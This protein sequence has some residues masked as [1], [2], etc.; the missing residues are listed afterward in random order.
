M[1][2]YEYTALDIKG[3][4]VTGI[5]DA[6]SSSAARQK[7]RTTGMYPVSISESRKSAKKESRSF[8]SLASFSRISPAEISLTTRQMA[9][10]VGSGFPL[11]SAIDA[12]V[13]QTKSKGFKKIMAQ[14]K[15]SIVEG[16]SFSASLA[17]Y[18]G[19]F[20]PI[21]INMVSAGETSGTLELV[22]ERLADITEKQQD[23]KNRISAAMMYPLIMC[24]MGALV[25]FILMTYIVP[26]ISAIFEQIDKVLPASTRFLIGTSSFLQAYWWAILIFLALAIVVFNRVKKTPGGRYFIDKT[27]LRLPGFGGLATKLA[28]ARFAR[29]LGS[30]LE[31]GVSMLSAMGIVKNIAGN[32]LIADAISDAATEVGKGQSLGKALSG[33][34]MFPGLAIQMIQ[35]GEQSGELES[36]LKKIADVYEKEV[37]STIM[38]LTALLE[39]VMILVMAV[40]VG[41]IVASIILPIVEMNQGIG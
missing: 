36:M 10:L 11:V 34:E 16:N 14:I 33:S 31:N 40:V 20:T 5:L 8:S 1:P 41:F 7:L 21:Y 13:E 2:V 39:P 19:I 4:S 18:P 27:I 35:V 6:E 3:K 38:R 23:L 9:T 30:L 24:G 28:T 29:T 22:L 17:Q 12:L 32:V 37:E 26:R 15:D 25:L